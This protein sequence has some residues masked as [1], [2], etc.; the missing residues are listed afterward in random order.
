MLRT[1]RFLI[2]AGRVGAPPRHTCV[3]SGLC[4]CRSTKPRMSTR[5]AW[6]PSRPTS[7]IHLILFLLLLTL[8]RDCWSQKDPNT[9]SSTSTEQEPVDTVTLNDT[10]YDLKMV[11]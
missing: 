11:S 8:V 4:C 10:H 1:S 3:S 6:Q 9:T 7:H 5:Q 2:I